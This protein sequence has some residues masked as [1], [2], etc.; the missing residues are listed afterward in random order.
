MMTRLF[1]S[2]LTSAVLLTPAQAQI[3]VDDDELAFP[4]QATRFQPLRT[5]QGDVP[6]EVAFG[7]N[8]GIV[9]AIPVEASVYVNEKGRDTS[10]W[11]RNP[12]VEVHRTINV[13]RNTVFVVP[14]MQG[15]MLTYGAF[16]RNSNV[17]TGGDH[18]YGFGTAKIF[19]DEIAVTPSGPLQAK[20]RA[21]LTLID[22][23]YDDDWSGQINYTLLCIGGIETPIVTYDPTK[24]PLGQMAID[25]RQ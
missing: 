12:S 6:P 22:D 3:I 11:K 20:T 16:N 9:C 10:A 24:I 5:P 25:P 18:H 15:W 21:V 23:N 1:A 4:E 17:T 7:A 14:A 19:V 13:P 8:L 2:L